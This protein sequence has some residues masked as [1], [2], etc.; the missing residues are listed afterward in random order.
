MEPR[1]ECYDKATGNQLMKE[2]ENELT[3][4]RNIR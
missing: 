4:A 3:L 2:K 1:E